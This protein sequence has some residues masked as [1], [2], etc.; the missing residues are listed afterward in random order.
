M[1]SFLGHHT[2]R[3]IYTLKRAYDLSCQL[4][5][6][7]L[8]LRMDDKLKVY[9]HCA[10]WYNG[11]KF[12]GIIETIAEGRVLL[13]T[14]S[15]ARSIPKDQI[16]KV[17]VIKFGCYDLRSWPVTILRQKLEA[18]EKDISMLIEETT[19]RGGYQ[20]FDAQGKATKQSESVKK[21]CE[22]LDKFHAAGVNY[23]DSK[24]MVAEQLGKVNSIPGPLTRPA[25]KKSRAAV[26]RANKRRFNKQNKKAKEAT[27]LTNGVEIIQ[28]G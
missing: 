9:N 27:I 22:L 3:A 14:S 15:G 6:K 4:F 16:S 18:E 8:T 26:A 19:L 1:E 23:L 11:Y 13:L 21:M 20:E 17:S 10:I 7:I 5:D 28:Q 25:K 2:G 12:E 24:L